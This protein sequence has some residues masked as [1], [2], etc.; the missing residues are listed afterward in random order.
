MWFFRAIVFCAWRGMKN[1]HFSNRKP[2]EISSLATRSRAASCYIPGI[3]L[4]VNSHLPGGA[5]RGCICLVYHSKPGQHTKYLT[6]S[7]SVNADTT[8]NLHLLNVSNSCHA[9][10]SKHRFRAGRMTSTTW[11]CV[12]RPKIKYSLI[13]A[14]ERRGA[15]LN[16]YKTNYAH[17]HLPKLKKARRYLS[18][19]L[20][21]LYP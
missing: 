19:Y 3:A 14:L 4:G 21:I 2:E 1:S 5:G 6:K 10:F 15:K 16:F 18:V 13:Y 9:H 12:F 7:Y 8:Q 11:F 17:H 20:I